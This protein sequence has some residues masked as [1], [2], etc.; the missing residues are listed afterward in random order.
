M[1]LL[2]TL[3]TE[4]GLLDNMLNI[5]AEEKN[6]LIK[7]D[8]EGIYQIAMKKEELKRRIEEIEKYRIEVWGNAKLKE[9][10]SLLDI[11]E[12]EEAEAVG[13]ALERVVQEI[14]NAN[15]T[16]TLLV[17]QSLDYARMMIN[18]INPPKLSVYGQNGRVESSREVTGRL[19]TSI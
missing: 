8:I 10:I 5:L 6:V 13:E 9:L 12:R 7:N 1:N 15:D 16:N 3:K 4:K 2:D 14:Q 18:T 17:K 19:N 11:G